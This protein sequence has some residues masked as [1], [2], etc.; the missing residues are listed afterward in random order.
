MEEC[1]YSY[2]MLQQNP[3]HELIKQ[4]NVSDVLFE[5]ENLKLEKSLMNIWLIE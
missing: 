2:G 4:N 5:A 1:G 3:I